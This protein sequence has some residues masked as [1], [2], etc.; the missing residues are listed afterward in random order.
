MKCTCCGKEL[1][2]TDRFCPNCGQNN[3]YFV[4]PVEAK[5][6]VV[7]NNN[8]NNGYINQPI[9]RVP[10]NNNQ[11]YNNSNYQNNQSYQQ[12]PVV[13]VQQQAPEGSGI[14]VAAL[15]FGLL[16]GWLGLVFGIIGLCKYKESGNR[17]MCI[18]GMVAWVVWL[19]IIIA[20]YSSL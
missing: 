3:E 8:N 19:V 15:I 13:V 2:S 9:N 10:I 12:P 18:V 5:P 17:A 11:N 4:E 7:E 6:E 1:Y 16:G 14:A 20:I